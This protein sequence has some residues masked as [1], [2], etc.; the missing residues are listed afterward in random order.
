MNLTLY[1]IP[2][3][4]IVLG[5]VQAFR[6]AGMPAR[7]APLAAIAIGIT[8]GEAIQ[9]AVAHPDYLQGAVIGV[10]LGLSASGA[11]SGIAKLAQ[12][13]DSSLGLIPGLDPQVPLVAPPQDPAP[14]AP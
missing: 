11:Y 3:A 13:K 6:E 14:P 2:I 12:P 8:A 7:L 10:I 5:L 1:G 4:V 9:R